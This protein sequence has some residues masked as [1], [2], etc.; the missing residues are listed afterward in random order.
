[1]RVVLDTNVLIDGYLDDFNAQ[2]QLIKAVCAG[3]LTALATP[4]TVREY[5]LILRRRIDNEQYHQQIAE[6]IAA[7]EAV[8]PALVDIT[9]D[10]EDDY[11]FVAA[12]VG[13]QADLL[14]TQDH[15][16]LQLGEVAGVAL[17]TPQEA[18]IKF[19]EETGSTS[20]WQEWIRGLGIRR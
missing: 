9:I 20:G 5:R 17:V 19:Q 13:G 18:W 2:A 6:F 8:E 14:V 3:K 11:K 10:D 7:T 1:M 16:L 4:P 15:H 12:A